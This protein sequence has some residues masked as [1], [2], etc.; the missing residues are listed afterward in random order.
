M[1]L[2][3]VP[4]SHIRTASPAKPSAPII[5]CPVSRAAP[6]AELAALLAELATLLALLWAL[7]AAAL[8]LL[9][10]LLEKEELPCTL[11][12]LADALE[13]D[14]EAEAVIEDTA[15]EADERIELAVLGSPAT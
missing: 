12:A 6:L 3:C 4:F 2:I 10:T 11:L 8:K 13:T 7:L 9:A 14:A 15:D 1:N 5:A